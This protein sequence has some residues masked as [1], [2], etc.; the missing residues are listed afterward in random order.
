M[1]KIIRLVFLLSL[2]I[3]SLS[4]ISCTDK[5]GSSSTADNSSLDIKKG[6]LIYDDKC[7][8]CHGENAT[9]GICPN[10]TDDEW[11]YGSS[12]K[13]FYESIAEGRPSG[14]PGWE[15][16]LGKEKIEMIIS[17]IRSLN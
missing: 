15:E 13:D 1:N 12:D 7:L 17:Y 14:M 10:L 6:K 16:S 3:F 8:K 5:Q 11:K 9:G 4:V 2:L